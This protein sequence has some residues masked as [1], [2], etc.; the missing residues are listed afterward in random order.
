MNLFEAEEAAQQRDRS[1]A[2]ETE[3]AQI[4]QIFDDLVVKR[5][6]LGLSTVEKQKRI[7]KQRKVD[8]ERN[9][10]GAVL[11][12]DVFIDSEYLVEVQVHAR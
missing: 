10:K 3:V 7:D 1:V 8:N 12:N 4:C 9:V 6:E 2:A 5:F 11:L